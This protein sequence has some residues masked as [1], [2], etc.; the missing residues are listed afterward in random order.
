MAA[1]RIII[2]ANRSLFELHSTDPKPNQM[3]LSGGGYY[4]VMLLLPSAV[5]VAVIFSSPCHIH[6]HVTRCPSAVGIVRVCTILRSSISMLCGGGAT[7]G[8]RAAGGRR[9]ESK[10]SGRHLCFPPLTSTFLHA[11]HKIWRE[12]LT[13]L[14]LFHVARIIWWEAGETAHTD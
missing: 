11:W 7:R 2:I 9:P 10:E 13:R 14:T 1:D 4:C 5:G 3:V 12:T 8:R 6:E